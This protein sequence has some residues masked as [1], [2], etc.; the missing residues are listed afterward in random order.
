MFI[1]SER[2]IYPTAESKTFFPYQS[3]LF[4]LWEGVSRPD[5]FQ[6]VVQVVDRLFHLVKPTH[7]Y[8]GEKDF[9]QLTVIKAWVKD[10]NIPVEIVSCPTLREA[11]GLAMSS[12]N[13]YLNVQ[14]RQA[15]ASLYQV[16]ISAKK[17]FLNGQTD[18]VK[19][20]AQALN[21]LSPG[22]NL[23]YFE[24]VDSQNLGSQYSVALD[25]RL[26]IAAKIGSVRLID[27]IGLNHE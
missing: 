26:M 3:P 18:W 21:I 5:H 4:K 27:N 9:Q 13:R 6:G 11:D 1:P 14:E 12:R 7:A 15:A 10:K 25:C 23:D 19:I 24:C 22:F 16:L 20:R 2:E 8:F 17:L